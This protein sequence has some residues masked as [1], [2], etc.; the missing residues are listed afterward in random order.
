MTDVVLGQRTLN[1]TSLARQLLLE[2]ST[3]GPLDAVERL[4]GLQAQNPL[5]PYTAL[6][7]RLAGFDA[8]AVGRLVEDRSLVRIAVMRSTVHLVTAADALR[9]RPISQPVLDKE[10]LTH[11]EH[12]AAF[13]ALDRT[14]VL[15][16]GRRLLDEAPR[17]AAQLR[18]GIAEELP[19]VDAR[20]A[21]YLCRNLLALVQVPPRGVWGRSGQVTYRTVEHWLGAPVAADATIDDLVPRYLAAY[22]PATVADIAAFTRLTGQREVV[23]RLRPQLRTYRNEQGQELFDVADGEIVDPDVPAPVRILPEYDNCLLSHADRTRFADDAT[24]ARVWETANGNGAVHGTITHDGHVVTTWRFAREKRTRTSPARCSFVVAEIDRP[25]KR[26]RTEI[27]AEAE[28]YLAF[29]EPEATQV[30]VRFRVAER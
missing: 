23:E 6:W 17:T 10:L 30:D 3:M 4:I 11:G 25:T 20:A 28:A 12:K 22:G 16:I 8:E 2:R 5:N 21:A 26:M 7:S 18:A 14:V 1:R 9:L 15:A 24:R 27:E 29:H 13:A 19:D